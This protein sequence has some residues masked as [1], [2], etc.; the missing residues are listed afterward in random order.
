MEKVWH[1]FLGFIFY[2]TLTCSLH[3]VCSLFISTVSTCFK[4]SCIWCPTGELEQEERWADVQKKIAPWSLNVQE[5]EPHLVAQQ[6][7][8]RLGKL[9]TALLVVA[10]L[11]DKPTNLGGMS[12][13]FSHIY[14]Y[15]RTTLDS[16]IEFVLYQLYIDEKT[17]IQNGYVN[18]MY[19]K[20]KKK[21]CRSVTFS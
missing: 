13:F 5:V 8:T 2:I 7:V 15:T 20:K 10:S 21:L 14:M 18:L 16:L 19:K 3:G 9:T 12:H 11:I 1:D 4:Y 6:R 17:T